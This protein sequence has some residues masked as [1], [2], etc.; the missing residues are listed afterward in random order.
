MIYYFTGNGNSRWV[1]QQ[2]ADATGDETENMSDYIKGDSMPLHSA[3]YDSIGIVFPIHSWYAPQ[4]VVQ[5]LSRLSVKAGAY[6]YVVCTYGDDCGQVARRLHHHYKFDSMWAVRM[7]NT[8]IPMFDLDS[9]T[10]ARIKVKE[11]REE[12]EYI[13]KD[14]VAKKKKVRNV[15]QG[16][17]PFCKTYPVNWLFYKFVV[18]SKG[19]EVNDS[20]TSCGTCRDVCPVGNIHL[21]DGRPVWNDKCIH[22][23][24]CVH[25]CPQRAIDFK[26]G[27]KKRGRYRLARYLK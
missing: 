9:D 25:A 4:P 5:F 11:A 20:C 6:K 15:F 19:F 22:C 18:T 21:E 23:M 8:Y 10:V 16:A 1:A 17:F 2:I 24:A 12:I 3:D 27:T 7:P 14:I 26:Q 13:S